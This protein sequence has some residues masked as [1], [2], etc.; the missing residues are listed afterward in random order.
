MKKLT[1][2]FLQGL[3]YVAP[4]SL[5][6]YV[7]YWL[8]IFTDNLLQSF[9]RDLFGISIPGLGVLVIII[10]LII[11]G[12]IGQTII[13]KPFKLLLNNVIYKIP[14]LKLIYSSLKDFFSAFVGKEKKFNRPVKVKLNKNDNI[15]R[16][17]FLTNENLKGFQAEDYVAVYFPF[18][19]TFTGETFLVPKESIEPINIAP[20]E[21]LK[22][23]MAGGVVEIES[24]KTLDD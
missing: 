15:L 17:G 21:V 1:G 7:I 14:I 5:T 13:A 16:I 11:L 12:L 6:F 22:F 23:L 4:I 18:S 10:G 2:Y 20:T 3:L 8:F 19:Y 9:F 24:S